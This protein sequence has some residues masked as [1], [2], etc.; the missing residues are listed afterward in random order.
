MRVLS[1][2]LFLVLLSCVSSDLA[3]DKRECSNQLASL[4][5]C[6]PFVGGRTKVPEPTCCTNIKKEINQ[7]RKC[8]CL[9][10]ADRNDPDLGFKVNATL[11]LTLPL[12][13]HAPSN[14][15]ECSELLH[16]APNSSD[17][18]VFE[19]FAATSQKGNSTAGKVTGTSTSSSSS[20]KE[21]WIGEIG[22]ILTWTIAS[23]YIINMQ[24]KG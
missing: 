13:C 3:K 21:G 8:L 10:V 17:A 15:S 12:L 11:A 20:L 16:L 19:Q 4:S 22:R 23:I 1:C 9:L 24:T 7:T 18:Q 5:T 6:I 14:A 2:L